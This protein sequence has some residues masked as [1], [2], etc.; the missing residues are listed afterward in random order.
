MVCA[1]LFAQEGTFTSVFY[2]NQGMAM[3]YSVTETPDSCF[4]VAGEKDFD[5]LILKMDST[6]EIVWDKVVSLGGSY[7]SRIIPSGDGNFIIAGTLSYSDNDI[8]CAKIDPQGDT[9]WVRSYDFGYNDIATNISGTSDNG[10]IISGYGESVNPY[11]TCMLALKIDPS[12]VVEWSKRIWGGNYMNQAYSIRQTAD[13]SYFLAGYI[14]DLVNAAYIATLIKLS[15]GGDVLWVKKI[16]PEPV[17][18]SAGYDL[19]V[20]GD[21]MLYFGKSDN[22]FFFIRTDLSGNIQWARQYPMYEGFS[23][24]NG[25]ETQL[26]NT[27][28][29]GY[30]FV[31]TGQFG[32]LL[33]TDSLGIPEWSSEIYLETVDVI[34][35]KENGFLVVGNGPL[36]GVQLSQ[37]FNPQIGMIRLDSTGNSV[38]C[39]YSGWMVSDSSTLNLIPFSVDTSSGVLL[40]SLHPEILDA[41]LSRDTGCVAM[42][43]SVHDHSSEMFLLTVSPNPSGGMITIDVEPQGKFMDELNIY[44]MTGKMVL[45]KRSL[46]GLPIHLDLKFL[47]DGIYMVTGQSDGKRCSQRISIVR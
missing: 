30:L 29:G 23:T 31:S 16:D 45:N 34:E 12:G 26:H 18:F 25:P 28:D 32:E 4:L 2:D 35:T 46:N 10:F 9:L 13:G 42:T 3:G 20:S 7:F 21:A 11:F 15:A 43:G 27:Y 8:V 6:G 41:S 39:V 33:K 22:I 38:N 1:N 17:Y 40:R 24:Y 37:T 47:P 44:D 19:Q 36:W 5:G 14:R